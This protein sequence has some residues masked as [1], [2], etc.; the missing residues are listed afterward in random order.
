MPK[1][2]I[3]DFIETYILLKNKSI[4]AKLFVFSSILVV[5]PVLAVGLISYKTSSIQLEEE[6]KQSSR[7]IME[8]VETHI[9]YYE[10][11]FEIA[12]LKIIN[13]PDFNSLL[14]YES[15]NVL[16]NPEVTEEARD[17][18]KNAVYSR[19]DISNITA[20]LDNGLVIDTLEERNYYP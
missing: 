15:K 9:E 20:I 1:N 7:Q 12:S 6:F 18:L 13:S 11:D 3:I 17:V 14:R 5:F 8:Q 4:M 19:P 16:Y 2:R 10:Q